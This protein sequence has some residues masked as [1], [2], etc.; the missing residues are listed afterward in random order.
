MS[1]LD[2]KKAGIIHKIVTNRIKKQLNNFK[3][4]LELTKYIE[5]E[6]KNLSNYDEKNPLKSGIGFPV[7]ININNVAAHFTP[8]KKNNPKIST[9]DIVKVDFGVHINGCICDGAFSYSLSDKHEK[10]I[11]AAEEATLVGI[12]QSGVDTI[13]GDI[14]YYIQEV[15]ESYNFKCVDDLC[16]HLIKPY[17]IHAGKCIPNIKINYKERMVENEVYAIET[18]PTDG[19]GKIVKENEYNHFAITN[20]NFEDKFVKKIYQKRKTLP[21]CPRW[22]NFNIPEIHNITKYPILTTDGLVAQYEKTI[23]VKNNSVEVLN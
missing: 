23:F 4:S 5:A 7:G 20:D 10:L 2:F 11:E 9:N 14:G 15:I 21:F 13:L 16:G 1:Y 22:F 12:K 6:I 17:V 19:S 3:S 8:S 18:F